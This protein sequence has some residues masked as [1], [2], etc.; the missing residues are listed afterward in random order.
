MT[1]CSSASSTASSRPIIFDTSSMRGSSAVEVLADEAAV[2]QHGDAVGDAVHLVEEV[3]DEQHGHAGRPHPLDDLEELVD[4]AGVEARRRLVEDQHLGVDLHR[5]GDRDEL[6][7]GDRVRLERRRRV[8]VEVQLL[9]HVGGAAAHRR[10][11]DPPEASRLASEH[12]V[13]GDREVGGQVDLLV[14][15]A[16]PGRLGLRRAVDVERLAAEQD[17]AARRCGR[18]RSAP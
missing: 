9:E 17:L 8:D 13:L 14:H 4:L 10:P 16:D 3:G 6:L 7:H 1:S 12:R 11:V 18:R 2:A 5:P 15:R